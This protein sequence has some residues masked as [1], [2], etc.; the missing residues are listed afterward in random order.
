MRS[1][2]ICFWPVIP[3]VAK[4]DYPGLGPLGRFRLLTGGWMP[5]EWVA[6][7]TELDAGKKLI[8]SRGVGMERGNHARIRFSLSPRAGRCRPG[9]LD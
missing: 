4:S 3:T 9:P 1:T 5:R 8:V 2:P 6:G 7:L